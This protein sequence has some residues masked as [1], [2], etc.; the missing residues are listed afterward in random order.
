MKI[1]KA[2]CIKGRWYKVLIKEQAEMGNN[3]GLTFTDKAEIWITKLAKG[4]DLRVTYLHEYMH[5]MFHELGIDSAIST[6]LN[7]ILAE[8]ISSSIDN[9]F[10]LR[11]R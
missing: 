8:G 11:H 1:P 9:N 2:I 4:R 7:E 3:W 6:Q 10:I 5:A